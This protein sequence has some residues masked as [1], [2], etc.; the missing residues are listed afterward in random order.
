MINKIK[1]FFSKVLS[2]V[3]PNKCPT[4]SK[5]LEFN[6]F[7]CGKCRK[8][9]I[10]NRDSTFIYSNKNV[11]VNCISPFFYSDVIRDMILD[12]K[13]R[14]CLHYSKFFAAKILNEIK[15]FV[16]ISSVD[17]ITFVPLTNAQKAKRG[18]NQSEIL[19]YEISKLCNIKTVSILKKSKKN[20]VQHE[21]NYE[22]RL[23][24]V[25]G[26][27]QIIDKKSVQN[28]TV[29]LCDDIVT[30]GSTLR[31]CSQILLSHGAKKIFCATIAKVSLN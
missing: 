18:Y 30:T 25:V 2:I 19:A 3:Y 9:I 29:L 10:P 4:C 16:S 17:L 31:E 8:K 26:V 21:L 5:I 6:C 20:F 22:E 24:N 28:K 7:L 1:S 13:F 11:E 23:K 15:N 14:N 12:F 27:Y